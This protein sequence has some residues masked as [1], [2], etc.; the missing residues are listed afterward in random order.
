M[1]IIIVLVLD[2]TFKLGLMFVS[3]ARSI[4][5]SG[6]PEGRFTQARIHLYL[7]ILN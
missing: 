5:E 7:Q 1:F 3:K 6:A 4:P 2:K